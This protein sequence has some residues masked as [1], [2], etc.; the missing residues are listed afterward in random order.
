[1]L[2]MEMEMEG[3]GSIDTLRARWKMDCNGCLVFGPF[4]F[5]PHL[6]DAFIQSDLQ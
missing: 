4:T 3:C 6:A 5:R 1:M 2:L